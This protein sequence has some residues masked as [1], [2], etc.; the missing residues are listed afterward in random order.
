MN[1]GDKK[2]VRLVKF[3]NGFVWAV[4]M[5]VC[6]AVAIFTIP[7]LFRITPFVVR[8]GSMEPNIPT[9]SVVFVNK[10]ATENIRIGDIVTF[11]LA[12]GDDDGVLVTHR[13][14][15]IDEEKNQIQTKG[16]ANAYPDGFI[17]KESVVGT[18][19]CYMPRVGFLL[20]SFQ[21]NYGYIIMAVSL[22]ILNIFAAIL[23]HTVQP[24]KQ[25]SQYIVNM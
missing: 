16:D 25:H 23:S 6:L 9:G 13:V 11:G 2:M 24:E 10:N 14:Y 7:Q 19:I 8:S 4:T 15:Q 22:A 1:R 3:F 21:S 18:V 5:F 17:S 20:E 12:V